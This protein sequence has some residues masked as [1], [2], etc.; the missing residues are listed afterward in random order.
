MCLYSLMSQS[1]HD[2]LNLV[3]LSSD[4]NFYNCFQKVTFV[5]LHSLYVYSQRVFWKDRVL[6]VEGGKME[7]W[8]WTLVNE[9]TSQ[10]V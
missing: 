10:T 8:T 5:G 2:F 4:N 1:L 9:R 7:M 6:H 3:I